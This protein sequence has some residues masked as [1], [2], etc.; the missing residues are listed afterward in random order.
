MTTATQQLPSGVVAAVNSSEGRLMN[1]RIV[2]AFALACAAVAELA[3][4][5]Y[6]LT[7]IQPFHPWFYSTLAVPPMA[8]VAAYVFNRRRV[9][10]GTLAFY[11][12]AVFFVAL[13]WYYVHWYNHMWPGFCCGE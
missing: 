7:K 13:S 12:G 5:A 10:L 8:V 3:Y 6:V 4:I 11:I 9:T 1:A 2:A